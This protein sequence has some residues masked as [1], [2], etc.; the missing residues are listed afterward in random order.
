MTARK[1]SERPG[2]GRGAGG[3]FGPGAGEGAEGSGLTPEA[4]EEARRAAEE[5]VGEGSALRRTLDEVAALEVAMAETD[6]RLRA[7]EAA[8]AAGASSPGASAAALEAAEGVQAAAAELEAASS[9]AAAAASAREAAV[10]ELARFEARGEARV[11]SGLAALAA[12][13]AGA[14][15]LAPFAAAAGGDSSFLLAEAFAS[16][17]FF[18]VCYRYALR[19]DWDN[20]Q[21]KSRAVGAFAVARGLGQADLL[22]G[23][24]GL[25]G[26]GVSL[27]E[28][29]GQALLLAG[30]G[31]VMFAAAAVA[32]EFCTLQGWIAPVPGRFPPEGATPEEGS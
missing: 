12:G 30:E 14:A 15:A 24:G 6:A 27:G 32:L 25:A 8:E 21:I 23:G 2:R 16:S 20:T 26:E 29:L 13:A 31:A 5:A 17:A 10:V 7:A 11:A 3:G 19:C 9:A 22:L 28:A 18:G 1:G 4:Q